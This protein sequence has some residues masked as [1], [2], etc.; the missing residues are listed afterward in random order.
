MRVILGVLFCFVLVNLQAEELSI[1]YST[2]TKSVEFISEGKW[3]KLPTEGRKADFYS[4]YVTSQIK[5]GNSIIINEDNIFSTT[6]KKPVITISTDAINIVAKIKMKGIEIEEPGLRARGKGRFAKD[7][8]FEDDIFG[9]ILM[10]SSGY[11]F[12]VWV[13][14]S[15][16]LFTTKISASPEISLK[17]RKL[18]IRQKREKIKQL[19]V[20]YKRI[21]K[22]SKKIIDIDKR[23]K[24]LEKFLGLR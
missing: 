17:E 9:P 7:I 1:K 22:K 14:D 20:K 12:L 19:R 16:T 21:N 3:E 11:K 4:L 15:G 8:E 24:I 23:L 5:V 6:L 13:D 18:R 10:S 2:I